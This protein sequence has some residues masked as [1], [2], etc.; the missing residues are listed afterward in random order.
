MILYDLV[1]IRGHFAEGELIFGDDDNWVEFGFSCQLSIH[2]QDGEIT[3]GIMTLPPTAEIESAFDIKY[4][5]IS[6]SGSINFNIHQI[7]TDYLVTQAVKPKHKFQS[8][9]EAA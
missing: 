5:I 7:I 1:K 4:Q 2:H 9:W 3:N 8:Y 6:Q